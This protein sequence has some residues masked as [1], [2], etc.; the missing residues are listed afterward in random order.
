MEE[1][2]VP[3]EHLHESIEEKAEELG[4]KGWSLYLAIS[5]A[6]MA[7]LAALSSL[8]AGH[9]SD[10]ALIS[11]VKASDQW[12]FY[13]AKGI[14]SEITQLMVANNTGGDT[15]KLDKKIAQYKSDQADIKKTAQEDEEESHEHLSRHIILARAVTLFQVSIAISAISIM[16][17]KRFLWYIAIAISMAGIVQFIMGNM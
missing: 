12:A 16:T 11:Q 6:F 8:Q 17:K 10:E 14:K 2:E 5:T 15:V 13:Q 4:K 3:T 9:H 1:P 7:V